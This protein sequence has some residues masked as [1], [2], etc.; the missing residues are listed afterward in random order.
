M[1]RRLLALAMLVLASAA[2]SAC[3]NEPEFRPND[4]PLSERGMLKYRGC[5]KDDD[6]VFVHNGC[7]SCMNGADEAAINRAFEERWESQFKCPNGCTLMGRIPA[8]GSG[9]VTCENGLCTY[10]FEA[11]H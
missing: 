3:N 8:C 4:R 1:T 7:C 10:T 6:C 9:K 2:C 5:S 11:E